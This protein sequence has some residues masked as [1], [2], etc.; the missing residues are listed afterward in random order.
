MP[1]DDGYP[2]DD[3]L[4]AIATYSGSVEGFLQAARAAWPEDFG[5]WREAP[6]HAALPHSR[7]GLEVRL[8]TGGWSGCE[9]VVAAIE[10]T[11]FHALFW[12]SS[13]RGGVTTYFVPD[14]QREISLAALPRFDAVPERG[15]RMT[16]ST[17]VAISGDSPPPPVLGPAPEGS[18][19]VVSRWVTSWVVQRPPAADTCV[20]A[21]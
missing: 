13:L 3:E 18:Y 4:D 11:M 1:D 8:V 20:V 9:S 6:V 15:R 16:G 10:R 19:E 12:E 17:V 14:G 7:D 21:P 5:W 2:T